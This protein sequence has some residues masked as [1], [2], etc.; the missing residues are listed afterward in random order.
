MALP[1]GTPFHHIR[2]T[3]SYPSRG[4]FTTL[5]RPLFPLIGA[6]TCALGCLSSIAAVFVSRGNDAQRQKTGG[7][8]DFGADSWV[9]SH[10]H[11]SNP[12][13]FDECW[14]CQHKRPRAKLAN[15]ASRHSRQQAFFAKDL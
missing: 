4:G 1:T 12:G 5:D 14:K 7:A 11:E 2:V 3:L 8:V 10:C 9:Y 15:G 6:V 13:N